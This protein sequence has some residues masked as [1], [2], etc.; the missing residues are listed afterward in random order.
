MPAEGRA[1]RIRGQRARAPRTPRA[2]TRRT[3]GRPR[4]VPPRRGSFGA[5][6]ATSPAAPRRRDA[7]GAPRPVRPHRRAGGAA[8]VLLTALAAACASGGRPAAV[9]PEADP[10]RG[11]PPIPPVTGAPLEIR[12]VSPG[13]NQSVGTRESTFVFGRVGSGD[14][15]LTINGAP[16]PVAPNGAFLAFLPIPTATARYEL[17]A[18]RGADTARRT[19]PVRVPAA[20][21]ALPATGALVV[22]SGSVTPSGSVLLRPDEPVRVTVRAPRNARVWLELTQFQTLQQPLDS[23]TGAPRGPARLLPPPRLPMVDAYAARAGAVPAPAVASDDAATLWV[24]EASA[25]DLAGAGEGGGPRVVVARGRDT[26]RLRMGRVSTLPAPGTVPDGPRWGDDA[27]SRTRRFV[28]LGRPA[29]VPDTDRV[30]VGR[31]TPGGTYRWFF[32]PGTVAERTGARD[33]FTRVRLD[34]DLEVWVADD[35]A[36]ALPVGY[37]PPPR[38]VGGARVAPAPGWVDLVLPMAERPAFEVVERGRE[39]DLVLYGT[40]LT[41]EILPILGTATDSLVRQLVWSQ[42]ASDRVRVTLR[43]SRAPYGHLVLWE[44]GALVLRLRR[45]PQVDAARP[46]AGL[47]IAVD[48]GHPP[49]GATG[50]TGLWE[51][52]AV[53]P[54]AERVRAMLEARGARVVMTRTSE[55]AVGLTER[56]VQARRADAHAFV[57][58]HLNAF[59][60]GVNPFTNNGTSV[61]F[62][63]QHSE[64]LARAIQERLIARLGLR[65]LGI[66]YQNLAV[67]RP[68]WMPA[69]L[70]E[71]LFLMV[72][73]QE[74]ALRSPAGRERYARAIVE[75]LE[76]YFRAVARGD[77]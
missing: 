60:D 45:A 16:V 29:A 12:V 52:V 19:V 65:D 72:P 44:R 24:R 6:L 31:P 71:G 75:G 1:R 54:V 4:A 61:L 77:G 50:P 7:A 30:I 59:P 32:L 35:D 33:G 14:A 56:G 63:H 66:H 47:T 23:V 53:L 73:E 48:A 37:A 41:P 55:A 20:R 17:V 68:P 34:A 74:A 42:E 5:M 15:T 22:D 39:V 25:V 57:S 40:Q 36:T 21:R 2:G 27:D 13:A 51:P 10:G 3:L 58:V 26:V 69:V 64:P 62:F 11:I 46:L 18:V 9:A 76:A 43:L 28:Q 8:L 70:T 67:A 38:V 49:G